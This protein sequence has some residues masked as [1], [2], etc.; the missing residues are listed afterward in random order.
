MNPVKI[1]PSILSAD[2]SRLKEEIHAVEAA[3]WASDLIESYLLVMSEHK[4]AAQPSPL[5]QFFILNSSIRHPLLDSA[6]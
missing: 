6:R 5:R 3:F 2:F 4:G 1:A